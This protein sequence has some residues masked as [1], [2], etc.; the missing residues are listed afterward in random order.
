MKPVSLQTPRTLR[1][2]TLQ[3]YRVLDGVESP[4]AS[5]WSLRGVRDGV[6]GGVVISPLVPPVVPRLPDTRWL[7]VRRASREEGRK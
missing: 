6:S 2:S 5:P 3:N 7:P 1:V 4:V